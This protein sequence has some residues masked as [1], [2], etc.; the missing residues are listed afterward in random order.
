[1][2]VLSAMCIRFFQL[3]DAKVWLRNQ[4]WKQQMPIVAFANGTSNTRNVWDPFVLNQYLLEEVYESV[5]IEDA[6]TYEQILLEEA[7]GE[8]MVTPQ[9]D[10]IIYNE[11]TVEEMGMGDEEG[12]EIA[13]QESAVFQTATDKILTYNM[14]DYTELEELVESFYVVDSQTVVDEDLLNVEELLSKNMTIS[15]TSDDPQILIYHTHSQE[16]F[17]DSIPGDSSTT[18]VGA[19]TEL[20]RILEEDY[21][22]NV[23]HDTTEYDLESRDEA[24]TL[25]EPALAAIL[26][27]YPSIEVM[28]DLHRDATMEHTQLVTTIDGVE[29]AQVMFFNGLSRT[30][31]YG[32]ISYLPNPNLE[33]NLAFSFQMQVACNEYYEGFTRKIYLKGYRY[34]LHFMGKSLLIELGA[35][36]NTVDQ[37]MNACGPIAH[38]LHMVLSG[39]EP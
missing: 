24:Y 25:A 23:I 32:E 29:M 35:Q 16:S 18:I 12:Q 2:I 37:I 21:G 26:E 28:I 17:V 8:N 34:N 19:G 6:Y 3:E 36:T 5:A 20:A 7:R 13:I 38:A 11:S 1:M 31:E 4:V 10:V 9:G 30:K 15:G 27:E 39:E 33:E 22:Y 14:E